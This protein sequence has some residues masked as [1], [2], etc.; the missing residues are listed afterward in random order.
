MDGGTYYFSN[1]EGHNENVK[2]E[3]INF[4]CIASMDQAEFDK[5]IQWH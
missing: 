4:I 5:N 3:I 2:Y 1:D